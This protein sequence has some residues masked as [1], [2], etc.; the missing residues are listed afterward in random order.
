MFQASASLHVNPHYRG[1][2]LPSALMRLPHYIQ[3]DGLIVS[4]EGENIARLLGVTLR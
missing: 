2:A 3:F 4:K 1:R